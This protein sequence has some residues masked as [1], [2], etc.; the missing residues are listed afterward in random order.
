MKSSVITG[1]VKSSKHNAGKSRLEA[2]KKQNM[3]IA[4]ALKLHDDKNNPK[5]ES[6]PDNPRVY[7]VKVVRTFLSASV[8]ISKIPLFRDF[9]RN[10]GYRL[11]DQCRMTDM[12]P[13]ILPQ[14]KEKIKNE[15]AGKYLSLI[16]DGTTR[17]GEV[18]VIVI[19]FVD[20]NWDIQQR[21]IKVQVLARSL[22]GEEIACEVINSLSL[23]YGVASEQ[24]LA[25]MHDCA[26]TN[27]VAMRTLKVLYPY[28][29]GIG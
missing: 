12:V 3:E 6:L 7:R 9:L 14:E 23:E 13:L 4:E 29:L 21:L 28:A 24:I 5:G 15:I 20:S 19:R 1:H 8:P 11:T 2:K 17:L 16:F 22:S 27:M 10:F 25:V 18:F 26:S